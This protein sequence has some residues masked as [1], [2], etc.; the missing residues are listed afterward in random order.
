L[1]LGHTGN[2]PGYTTLMIATPNGRRSAV[3]TVNEQLAENAR[4]ETFEHLH[5]VFELAACA[6][7]PK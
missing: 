6:A 4:P 7:L 3:V 1:V 5:R 2:F